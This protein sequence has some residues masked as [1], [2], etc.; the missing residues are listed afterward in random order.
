MHKYAVSVI[1]VEDKY[2]AIYPVGGHRK[3]SSAVYGYDFLWVCDLG[4]DCVCLMRHW[5]QWC[6]L[7]MHGLMLIF[8]LAVISCLIHMPLGCYHRREDIF[9]NQVDFH[10]RLRGQVSLPGG[11]YE[12][13]LYLYKQCDMVPF[14]Q[15]RVVP[16]YQ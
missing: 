2:I 9:S 5:F 10:V 3:L 13:F 16:V 12:N 6:I 7:L 11:L 4:E 1:L 14:F 15:F 8:V